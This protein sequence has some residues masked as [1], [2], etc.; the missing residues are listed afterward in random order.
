MRLVAG[1]LLI[2]AL[3]GCESTQAKSARLERSAQ[4]AKHEKGLVI[5]RDAREVQVEG[6]TLLQQDGSAATVVELHNRSTRSLVALPIGLTVRDGTGKSVYA[7][8][9]PG[10]DA[11]LVQIPA[12]APGQRLAWVNDQI[13]LPAPGKDAVARVGAGGKPGPAQLPQMEV[14]DLKVTTDAGGSVS[15]VGNVANRSSIA[16]KRLIVFVVARKGERVVAAGRAIV[17]NLPAGKSTNF[18]AFPIGD[19]HGAK[20][21]AAAPPTV[22]TQ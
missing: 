19:P 14:T 12:L 16:Q 3:A 11:S 18:S 10:L 13:T 20:L 8:D 4:K 15:V 9:T 7:N 2:L 6:A 21:S 22:V 1:A 17:E 5:T